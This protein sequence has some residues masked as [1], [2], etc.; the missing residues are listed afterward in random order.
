MGHFSEK[1]TCTKIIRIINEDT[2]LNFRFRKMKKINT[3]DII[4]SNVKIK[5]LCSYKIAL[6][7]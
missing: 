2:L 7:H 4:V 3:T 5:F 6:L 1:K